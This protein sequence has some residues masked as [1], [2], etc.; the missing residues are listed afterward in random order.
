MFEFIINCFN[1][2]VENAEI[3]LIDHNGGRLEKI[4]LY[5]R[6]QR[7]GQFEENIYFKINSANFAEPVA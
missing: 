6:L 2:T 5:G 1:N 4:K 7:H 3:N